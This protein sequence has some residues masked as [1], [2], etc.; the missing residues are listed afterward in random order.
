MGAYLGAFPDERLR[1]QIANRQRAAPTR[2]EPRGLVASHVD[3]AVC[4]VSIR[5]ERASIFTLDGG[6]DSYADV[7]PVDLIRVPGG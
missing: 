6:Y 1:H 3:A 5:L 2:S 7:L 4:A